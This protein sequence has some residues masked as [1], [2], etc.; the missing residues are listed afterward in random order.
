[1]VWLKRRG[2]LHLLERGCL[3]IG[4]AAVFATVARANRE[5]L[6]MPSWVEGPY[7]NA[8]AKFVAQVVRMFASSSTG[9]LAGGTICLLGEPMPA[10]VDLSES[11]KWVE[12]IGMT[13]SSVKQKL[14][15]LGI[16]TLEDA[17][18]G[19]YTCITALSRYNWGIRGPL[20]SSKLARVQECRK[21][22][23]LDILSLLEE[24]PERD[25]ALQD[26]MEKNV[27]KLLPHVTCTR[28][29]KPIAGLRPSRVGRIPLHCT[30]ACRDKEYKERQ[31]LKRKSGLVSK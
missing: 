9:A 19:M 10:R 23:G 27:V 6:N 14:E 5:L 20:T 8:R 13:S 24:L 31:K 16:V 15:M 2:I 1:M 29:K 18:V 28:C 30:N 26:T 22:T 17:N 4:T 25:D 12:A 3:V 21:L 11:T 7:H